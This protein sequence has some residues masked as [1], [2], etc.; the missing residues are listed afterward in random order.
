MAKTYITAMT[1]IRII[2]SII[3]G[4]MLILLA[5]LLRRG[6]SS[7]PG[8]VALRIA[9][10]LLRVLAGRIE[11]GVVAVTA[12]NG[13]TTTTRMLAGLVRH[14][15][16][17]VVTNASGA[18]MAGGIVSAMIEAASLLGRFPKQALAIIEVDEGSIPAVLPKLLPGVLLVGNFFRDQL[19]RYG[20]VAILARR[21]GETVACLSRPPRLVINADDPIAASLGDAASRGVVWFG[22]DSGRES[23]ISA[24]DG[25][26]DIRH[27]PQCHGTLE[28]TLRLMGHLG[29]YHCPGC[30]RKR[31][32]PDWTARDLRSSGMTRQEFRLVHRDGRSFVV[33]P[34]FP[35]MHAVYNSLAA[36]ATLD[37][38][39]MLDT[40]AV[41]WL[42]EF[43]PPYGRYEEIPLDGRT[44]LL[45][46]VKNPAGANASLDILSRHAADLSVLILLN[47]LAA[48]GRDISWIYDASFEAIASAQSIV[49][50][51]RRAQ[52][53]ALRML[54]SGADPGRIQAVSGEA[55]AAL[56][57]ALEKTGPGGVLALIATYTAMHAVR[58]VLVRRA[59]IRE[60]WKDGT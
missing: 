46:L 56:D 23:G 54:H 52:A 4:K 21:V 48:D 1:R 36:L 53:M 24:S 13:K 40:G 30:G 11:G 14:A 31:P 35:G 49:T 22:V 57:V 43:R 34:G 51:G 41:Q 20:E 18:N 60:F 5:R 32:E 3:I 9:P 45:M 8:K 42:A 29:T 55:G 16:R 44:I 15:G 17:P 58:A 33:T 27:C 6:G 50:G 25:T 39:N 28:Y 2:A 10:G 7:M 12:T 47:D 59:G 26:A 19:D 37:A 38:L